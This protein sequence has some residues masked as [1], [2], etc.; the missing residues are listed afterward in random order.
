MLTLRIAEHVEYRS[1]DHGGVLLLDT[2]AG[3]W[4]ALN[5]T[6]GEFWRSW[7]SGAKFDEGVAEVAAR[8]PGVPQE[9]IRADAEQLVADLF[10]R[11]LIKVV[12]PVGDGAV[13]VMGTRDQEVTEQRPGGART[14]AAFLVLLV[15]TV[16]LWCPFRVSYALVRATRRGWCRGAPACGQVV[17]TASAV[18]RAARYFPGRVACLE[19]SLAVVLLSAMTRKRLDWCLGSAPDPYRFHAWVEA[20]GQPVLATGDIAAQPGYTRVLSV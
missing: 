17:L 14:V 6:A 10:D 20:A 5:P 2:A 15:A 11:G 12:P 19:Q 18:S 16:L 7:E 4:L 1:Q 9:E 8:H 13:A 3:L